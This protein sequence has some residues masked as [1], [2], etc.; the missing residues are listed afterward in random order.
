MII[1]SNENIYSIDVS[2]SKVPLFADIANYLAATEM[3]DSPT[4]EKILLT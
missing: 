4:E 2:Y 1:F 3:N